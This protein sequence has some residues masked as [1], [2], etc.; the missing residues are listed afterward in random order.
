VVAYCDSTIA[1]PLLTAYVL[2]NVPPRP[3]K[4]L[5]DRREEMT[6][7]LRDAHLATRVSQMFPPGIKPPPKRDNGG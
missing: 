4:R 2:E 7:A 6:E 1:L 5:Y 3:L